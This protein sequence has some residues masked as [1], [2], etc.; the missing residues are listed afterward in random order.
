MGTGF[1]FLNLSVPV[2]YYE[3]IDTN[4]AKVAK[5]VGFFVC[6]QGKQFTQTTTKTLQNHRRTIQD[7]RNDL[8]SF[9]IKLSINLWIL[10]I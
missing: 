4:G 6:F 3:N 2:L 9:M 1:R 5:R 8:F 10:L 7:H